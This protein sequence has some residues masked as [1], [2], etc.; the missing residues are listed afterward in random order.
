MVKRHCDT[1]LDTLSRQ[2]RLNTPQAQSTLEL[3]LCA[4]PT[5]MILRRATVATLGSEQFLIA[6]A[7]PHY[8][9]YEATLG[10]SLYERQ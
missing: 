7:Q 9:I 4:R 2:R 6:N 8:L 10:T 1:G 3:P 5:A